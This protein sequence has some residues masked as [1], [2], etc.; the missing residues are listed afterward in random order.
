MGGE[1]RARWVLRLRL[2]AGRPLLR[3]VVW[4]TSGWPGPVRRRAAAVLRPVA[5][6]LVYAE[7]GDKATVEGE[8]DRER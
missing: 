3:L 1:R 4:L 6:R 8:S 2:A 7:A 5:L